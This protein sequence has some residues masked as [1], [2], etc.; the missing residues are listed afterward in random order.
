MIRITLK[1][2]RNSLRLIN[3]RTLNNGQIEHYEMVDLLRLKM[4]QCLVVFVKAL[5]HNPIVPLYL[6]AIFIF[7]GVPKLFDLSKLLDMRT[8]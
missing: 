7:K 4:S 8:L 6:K 5:P 1:I 2:A 3:L